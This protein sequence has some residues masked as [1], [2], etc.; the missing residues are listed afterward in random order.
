M[1]ERS[2]EVVRV[3]RVLRDHAA[4]SGAALAAPAAAGAAP[5]P[6]P[7]D[8]YAVLG[9]APSDPGPAIKKRYWRLSLLIHPDK[10]AH[11]QAATAFQAVAAAA[12]ELQDAAARAAVDER[13]E[14][15][16]L[17]RAAAA[18]AAQEERARQWRVARGEATPQDLEGPAGGGGGPAARDAWMTELP[19]E[20]T[21]RQ[22]PPQGNVTTFSAAGIRARGD[23]SAWTS[24]PQERAL[25][26]EGG[27]GGGGA[28]P[29]LLMA[30]A[31]EGAWQQRTA[32][33]VDAYNANAR[34]KTLLE[35][36]QE[37][38]AGANK[39][40]KK[41]K[42]E[43]KRKAAGPAEGGAAAGPAGA[44][45][46]G[47]DWDR[48]AHPWRP[49]DR[50]KDLDSGPPKASNPREMLNSLPALGSRFAGTQGG[51]RSFL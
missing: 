12:A 32:A 46:A 33:V 19:P 39:R 38:Q 31:A 18:H 1:D 17:R 26:I 36:H 8:A 11:E 21:V 20:A 7:P 3:L 49:F 48:A 30:A 10:C 51:G 22:G 45:A 28:G 23:T 16:A 13:R 50:E 5:A 25:R 47:D 14:E 44:A 34:G 27:G 24:T 9:A 29:A 40:D 42:R 6:R 41:E 4:A 43:K 15:A 35:A 2:A 37:R